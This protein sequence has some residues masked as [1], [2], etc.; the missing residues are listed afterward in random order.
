MERITWRNT[1]S[2]GVAELDD[3]HKRLVGMINRLIDEQKTLTTPETIAELITEMTDYALEHFR[4]EEYLMAE[5]GYER[6]DEHVKVHHDFINRTQGFMAAPVGP[7]LLSKE[8]LEFLKSWLVG[9]ILNEDMQYK[10]LFQ[11][12]GV[13]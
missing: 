4:A 10:P 9:H 1:F 11:Q 5:Y 7:N 8:L 2:V 12:K 13:S 3:Q 6:K